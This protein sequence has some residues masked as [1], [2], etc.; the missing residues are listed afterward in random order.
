[1][2]LTQQSPAQF[3]A[4]LHGMPMAHAHARVAGS[5]PMVFAPKRSKVKKKGQGNWRNNPYFNG[6]KKRG[7]K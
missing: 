7:V 5:G 1:M 4:N 6:T 2:N 3:V